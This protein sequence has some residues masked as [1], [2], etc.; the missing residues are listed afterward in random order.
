VLIA[1]SGTTGMWG[2]N[3]ET[4]AELWRRDLPIGGVTGAEPWSGALLV[5][6][7]RYGLFLFHPLDGGVMDGFHS[8]GAFAGAAAAYGRRAYIITNEGTLFGLHI[9]PPSG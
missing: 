2:L 7:T 6:T 8:G 1:S 4:G 5:G 3:L 9:A